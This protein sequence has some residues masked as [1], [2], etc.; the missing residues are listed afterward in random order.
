MEM[1]AAERPPGWYSRGYLPHHDE[2]GLLQNITYRLADSVPSRLLAR[3]EEELRTVSAERV[4]LERRKRMEV[5]LDAGHG[6]GALGRPA[7]A[8]AVVE[9]WR[10]FDG[11]RYDLLAY[12]VM[13]THVH[14]L[15][16]MYPDVPLATVVRSWKS[17]TAKRIRRLA[18]DVFSSGPVWRRGYWDRAIRN[19]KHFRNAVEYI[20]NNP[21]KAGLV[22]DAADWPWSFPR[23]TDA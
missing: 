15:V 19:E 20:L 4:P 12:V 3:M 17:F 2:G 11:V 16:R 5:L 8:E 13:P 7:A 6:S 14:V 9:N 23:E 10:R 18:P 21:V 22:R 1:N